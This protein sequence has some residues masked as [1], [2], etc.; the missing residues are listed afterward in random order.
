MAK[1]KPFRDEGDKVK[2]RTKDIARERVANLKKGVPTFD[3]GVVPER[4][5]FPRAG[6]RFLYAD[7]SG[8]VGA[9]QKKKRR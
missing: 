2:P 9:M 3:K 7:K 1:M 4:D 8:E 6:R 5:V